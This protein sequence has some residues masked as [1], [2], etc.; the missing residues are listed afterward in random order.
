MPVEN[1]QYPY[2]VPTVAGDTITVDWLLRDPNRINRAIANLALQRFYVDR[3]FSPAGP[4]V[5]GAQAFEVALTNDLYPSR[6]VRRVEPGDS[7]PVVTFDRGQVFTAQVEKFGGKFPITDEAVR[8]NRIGRVNRAI[9]QLSNVILRKI[10]QRA[11][12]ELTAA[13]STYTRTAVGTSWTTSSGTAAGSQLATVGP[14]ADVTAVGLA[15]EVAELGYEYNYAIMNP[16][17]YRKGTLTAV[18]LGTTLEAM[19]AGYGIQGIWVTNRKAAGTIYW[20][21]QGQVGE[22]GYEVPLSQETWRDKDG[23]QQTWFQSYVLPIVYVTDPLAIL[24]TTGH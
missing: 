7:F 17:E 13:I 11:L 24:E 19:L 16:A 1:I 10:Q 8:R 12:A 22:L 21:A 20:L 14:I 18:A 23:K 4:I 3:V 15:N 5:G 2:G 6:D 9:T